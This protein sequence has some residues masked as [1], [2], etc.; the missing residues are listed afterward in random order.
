MTMPEFFELLAMERT[1]AE[2]ERRIEANAVFCDWHHEL[3]TTLDISREDLRGSDR[4]PA[5]PRLPA[6]QEHPDAHGDD[7]GSEAEGHWR[8]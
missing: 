6:C 3:L 8:C 2:I 7:A 5:K 1:L 4:R